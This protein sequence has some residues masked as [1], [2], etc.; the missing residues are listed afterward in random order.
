MSS[1]TV[2]RV[3][4]QQNTRLDETATGPDAYPRARRSSALGRRRL[5][6]QA[7]EERLRAGVGALSREFGV[8][9]MTIR[10]DLDALAKE[11]SV[12]RAHG[13]AFLAR[14]GDCVRPPGELGLGRTL[15]AA[16]A[17]RRTAPEPSL[18]PDTAQPAARHSMATS[19]VPDRLAN[20]SGL[21][22]S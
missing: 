15:S 4:V 6:R 7:I 5:I 14:S 8:S 20:R 3:R 19:V 12:V 13:G 21:E 9:E 11:G 18:A 1:P 10:R 16:R 2:T 22:S 17:K